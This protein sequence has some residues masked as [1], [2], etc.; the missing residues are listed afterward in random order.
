MMKMEKSKPLSLTGPASRRCSYLF[1]GAFDC[2]NSAG[3]LGSERAIILLN[4]KMRYFW[5][6]LKRHVS[7][8]SEII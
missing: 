6:D 1:I 3:P 8:V 4:K 2:N 7:I 5:P